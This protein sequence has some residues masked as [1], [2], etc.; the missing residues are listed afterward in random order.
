MALRPPIF[1]SGQ[2]AKYWCAPSLIRTVRIVKVSNE[3]GRWIVDG[4]FLDG[5]KE[6]FTCHELSLLEMTDPLDRLANL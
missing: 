6:G 4:H 2:V 1:E 5:R 3:K